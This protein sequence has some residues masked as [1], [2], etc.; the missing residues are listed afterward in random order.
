[1]HVHYFASLII[2]D[3]GYV[4]I[5]ERGGAAVMLLLDLSELVG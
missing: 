5:L 3:F 1:V 2:K 4:G